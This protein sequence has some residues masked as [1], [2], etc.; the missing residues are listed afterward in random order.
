MPRVNVSRTYAHLEPE[1][2]LQ[3]LVEM[4]S[5]LNSDNPYRNAP[6]P[7]NDLRRCLGFW[8]ALGANDTVISWLRYGTPPLLYKEPQRYEFIGP[9]PSP[10]DAQVLADD[11]AAHT[12][13][14]TFRQ[15]PDDFARIVSPRFVDTNLDGKK[16]CIDDMRYPIS[17]CL[18]SLVNSCLSKMMRLRSSNLATSSR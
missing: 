15:V 8:K 12:S 6:G 5:Y 16:R 4:G 18:R 10:E 2:A 17:L 11:F 1:N 13:D 9:A 7:V 3:R 14:A